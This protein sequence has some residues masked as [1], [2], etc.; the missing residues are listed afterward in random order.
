MTRPRPP[1]PRY[2]FVGRSGDSYLFVAT[3]G[4]RWVPALHRVPI[5]SFWRTGVAG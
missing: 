2:R 3:V 4:S 1:R 5:A